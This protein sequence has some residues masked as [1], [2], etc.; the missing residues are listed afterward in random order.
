MAWTIEVDERAARQLGK[1]D[2]PD[3]VRIRNF[4]RDRLAT[5]DDPRQLGKAL[6]G[7]KL[8]NLWRYRVGDFR[9]ICDLQDTRLVVLVVGVGN[10]RD[11]YR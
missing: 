8:G 9:I 6:Q 1:L 10:R 2:R 4:L 3:A 11:I 7:S 5:L